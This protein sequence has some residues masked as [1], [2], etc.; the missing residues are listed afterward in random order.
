MSSLECPTRRRLARSLIVAAL[1]GV[2]QDF[3]V[4]S[5]YLGILD[6]SYVEIAS[7]WSSESALNVHRD[8]GDWESPEFTKSPKKFPTKRNLT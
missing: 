6:D 3:S 8:K 7:T 1:I 5:L 2:Q 4:L